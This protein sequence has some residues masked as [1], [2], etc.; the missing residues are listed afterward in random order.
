MLP[1]SE[2]SA[3]CTH[4][5]FKESCAALVVVDSSM[6]PIDRLIKKVSKL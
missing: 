4:R 5:F 6:A 1:R 3:K 2:E